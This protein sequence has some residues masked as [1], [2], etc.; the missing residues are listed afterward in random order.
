MRKIKFLSIALTLMVAL[1]STSVQAQNITE[2]V[3]V[4]ELTQVPGE[5]HTTSLNL[6]PG[7]YQFTVTNES[8]DKEVGFVIQT[9]ADKDGDV[10]KTAYPNSFS[11][12]LIAKGVTGTSGIVDLPAGEYVYSCPLNATP[13][14]TLTVK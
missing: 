14:Y 6:K 9:A 2:G 3:T 11:K 10:M 8:V 7:K 1:F 5:F 13:K 12:S 4:V